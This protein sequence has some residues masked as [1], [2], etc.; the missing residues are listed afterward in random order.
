M[1][2]DPRRIQILPYS[3]IVGQREL[4]DALEIGFVSGLGVLATGQRGTAKSTTIRAFAMAMYGRLPITM[5]LGVTDDRVLGGFDIVGLLDETPEPKWQQGLLAQ[6]DEGMLYIDEINLLEDHIVNLVLDAATGILQVQ[7]EGADLP[8]VGVDFVL[9]GSMNPDEGALRPQLLDRFGMVVPVTGESDFATRRAVLANVLDWE[10]YREDETSPF[11]TEATQ[12]DEALRKRLGAA[13]ELFPNVGHSADLLDTCARVAHEFDIVGH[14]GEG[15][16]A[17]T[18]RA[19][20]A[21]S[22]DVTARARHLRASVVK[23]VLLHRRSRDNSGAL[24]KWGPAED[25]RLAE[26]LQQVTG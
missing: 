11:M 19:V 26:A 14:R 6:A 15:A 24:H 5:P 20:A 3:K 8:P 2:S 7:R 1:S 21:L 12:A 10:L 18:A 16:M 25:A 13:R 9:A 17:R 4:C 23:A 22:G